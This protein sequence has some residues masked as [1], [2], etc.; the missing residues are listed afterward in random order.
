LTIGFHEECDARATFDTLPNV[1][2]KAAP[3]FALAGEQ[4]RAQ[5]TFRPIN[6]FKHRHVTNAKRKKQRF[7][8]QMEKMG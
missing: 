4:R 8:Q 7:N 1:L 5:I 3:S 6:D 2:K